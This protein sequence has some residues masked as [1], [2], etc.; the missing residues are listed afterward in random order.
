MQDRVESLIDVLFDETAREDERSDAAI[1][2]RKY[3]DLRAVEALTKVASDPKEDDVIIDNCAE[4][5]GEICSTMNL[6][7]EKLFKQMVPFAQR[8]V[9]RMLV[10]RNP[11]LIQQ[12]LRDELAKKF[13]E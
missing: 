11:E 12:P 5:L 10:A 3:K 13:N 2:L 7:N 9:F 4:S 1:D 8:I 6:F